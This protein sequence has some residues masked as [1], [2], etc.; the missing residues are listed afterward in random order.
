MLE[1][2]AQPVRWPAPGFL[3]C[4]NFYITTERRGETDCD[5]ELKTLPVLLPPL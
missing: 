4:L 1:N 5:E 3:Y 2:R